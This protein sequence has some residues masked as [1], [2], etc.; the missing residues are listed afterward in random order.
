MENSAEKQG[1]TAVSFEIVGK[2][3]E[4]AP[5]VLQA[6]N[7]QQEKAVQPFD[8]HTD[9]EVGAHTVKRKSMID[10]EQNWTPDMDEGPMERPYKRQRQIDELQQ[11]L[12]A[13]S[14]EDMERPA[15]GANGSQASDEQ[16]KEFQIPHNHEVPAAFP[17]EVKSQLH[18]PLPEDTEGDKGMFCR[19]GVR[20]PDGKR[21]QRT[22]LRSD[23]VQLLWPFCCSQVKEAAGGRQFRLA[24]IVPG[25]SEI[26]D[27]DLNLS[28]GDS[29][30]PNSLISMIWE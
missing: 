20:L 21:V 30:V 5:Q 11:A 24:Y 3:P 10:P 9:I 29:G 15:V 27:C 18:P 19:V 12:M 28:F 13:V 8:S 25:A 4:K 1:K 22:F 14:L 16:S 2:S 17:E 26:L 23:S 7:S 6:S